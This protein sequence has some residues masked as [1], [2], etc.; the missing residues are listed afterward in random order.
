MFNKVDLSYIEKAESYIKKNQGTMEE[1]VFLFFESCC[2]DERKIIQL[3]EEFSKTKGILKKPE[4][5]LI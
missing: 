2:K 3:A 5:N 1:E 4:V